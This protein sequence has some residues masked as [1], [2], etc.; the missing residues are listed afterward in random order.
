MEDASDTVGQVLALPTGGP[1]GSRTV[2]GTAGCHSGGGRMKFASREKQKG[3]RTP[4]DVTCCT[5]ILYLID[6]WSV[7]L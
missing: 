6:M 2:S 3:G 4:R 1:R 7:G 5:D